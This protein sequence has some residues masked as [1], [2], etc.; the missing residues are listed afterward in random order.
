MGENKLLSE[1]F[2]RRVQPSKERE[3]FFFIFDQDKKKLTVDNLEGF[4]NDKL[5]FKSPRRK[6]QGFRGHLELGKERV[7]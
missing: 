5:S 1:Q 6:V 3:I 7:A 2:T 4:A